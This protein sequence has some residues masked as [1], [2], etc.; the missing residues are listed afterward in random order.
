MAELAGT[1]L[2]AVR[3]YHEV[4]LLDPPERAANGYKQYGVPHLVRLVRIR[5]LV[6]LGMSLE[7][8]RAMDDLSE[9]PQEELRRLDAEIAGQV[10]RLERLRAELGRLIER[11]APVDLSPEFA[12]V[13]L[14]GA[15]RALL[16]VLGL[17][18]DPAERAAVAEL[19]RTQ[20]P[21][22][23]GREFEA[24]PADA[25]EDRRRELA[26][27]MAPEGV[28]LRRR[29]PDL[30]ELSAAGAG[31]AVGRAYWTAL[32]DIYNP[33]QLDVLRRVTRLRRALR[34]SPT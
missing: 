29:H 4:G 25:P 14:T 10:R 30:P 7:Q 13:S 24:L 8:V 21:T 31:T 11:S 3:H 18:L 23:A 16:V 12:S 1:T 22:E 19:L 26:E 9:H 28:E 2:R 17:V 34:P 27:R 5:R 33:A 20:P 6:E 32:A 15:D